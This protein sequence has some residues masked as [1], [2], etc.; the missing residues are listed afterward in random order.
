MKER[1]LT[2]LVL[3][4]I[5]LAIVFLNSFWPI[6]IAIF[7]AFLIGYGEVCKLADSASPIPLLGLVPLLLALPVVSGTGGDTT[8]LSFGPS[9]FEAAVWIVIAT[10]FGVLGC[11]YVTSGGR[12]KFAAE[13]TSL[14]L[15]IPLVS[16][17]FIKSLDNGGTGVFNAKSNILLVFI[18]LWI[19]DTMAYL[20]GKKF[21]KRLIA[22]K[23]SPKKTTVGAVAN[24]AGSCAGGILAA[25]YLDL[26]FFVGAIVGVVAGTFGQAGDLLESAMKRARGLKDS[27]NLLPGH[28]GLLD[29]IDSILLTAPMVAL[30]VAAFLGSSR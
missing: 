1:V 18:P 17:V 25:L 16:L 30:V 27:G 5:V 10:G 21:G 6:W 11:A 12:G 4:P 26:P 28:G 29:R 14:W 9:P 23:I 24:F 15:V 8:L 3:I 2:A 13:V 20:F 22:P 7:I 19:G